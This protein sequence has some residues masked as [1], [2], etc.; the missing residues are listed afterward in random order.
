M[1]KDPRVNCISLNAIFLNLFLLLLVGFPQLHRVA[2]ASESL[3][4][5]NVDTPLDNPTLTTEVILLA[6]SDSIAVRSLFPPGAVDPA[7]GKHAEDVIVAGVE[8][9]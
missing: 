8:S 4:P 6:D 7:D 5:G 2:L 1:A 3:A 9:K